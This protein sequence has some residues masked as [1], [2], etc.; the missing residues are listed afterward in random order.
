LRRKEE[1]MKR[2]ELS[3]NQ[4]LPKF[5]SAK[6]VMPIKVALTRGVL[7]V[8]E[9]ICAACQN[10]MYACTLSKDGVACPELA[11]IQLNTRWIN[12]PHAAAQPCQQCVDPQCMRYCPTRA[13]KVDDATGARVIDQALCIGCQTCIQTCPYE[14]SRIRFDRVKKKAI[15]CDLCG[16]DPACVKACPTGALSYFTDPDGIRSGYIQPKGR[17]Q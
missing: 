1:K 12:E 11:R 10:C 17:D 9:S 6:V 13:I 14:L 4:P 5:G 16:G 3:N 7:V 15:K 2:E 8:D